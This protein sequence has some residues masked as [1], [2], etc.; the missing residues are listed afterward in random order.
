MTRTL[1]YSIGSFFLLAM[2][3][4]TTSMSGH[5]MIETSEESYEEVKIGGQIWMTRNLNTATFRNGDSIMQAKTK[6]EWNAANRKNIPAWCYYDNDSLHNDTYGKLYNWSAVTDKRDLA[7]TGWHIP[8]SEEW[9]ILYTFLG[10]R[11]GAVGRKLKSTNGWEKNGNGD[12]SNGFNALPAGVRDIAL[13]TPND[14]YRWKG[15]LAIWWSTNK[16]KNWVDVE[17]FVV[18]NTDNARFEWN[19]P[20][21]G[22]SVRCIKD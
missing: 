15:T 5:Y 19:E 14:G 21:N 11:K 16:P 22:Y 10:G 9:H 20:W 17:C 18:R 7:P 6:E 13:I 1:L 2:M 3:I 12:N 4:L 8:S